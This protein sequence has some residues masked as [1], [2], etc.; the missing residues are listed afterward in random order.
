MIALR[1]E[2]RL[3]FYGPTDI[4]ILIYLR[5][6]K[7]WRGMLVSIAVEWGMCR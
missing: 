5:A 7:W 1:V 6:I 3:A 2:M 4:P